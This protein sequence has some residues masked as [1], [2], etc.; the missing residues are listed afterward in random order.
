MT[1][2]PQARC[3]MSSL[4]CAVVQ[5][6]VRCPPV[7]LHQQITWATCVNVLEVIQASFVT[8]VSTS[9]VEL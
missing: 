1:C 2:K 9:K 4:T 3:V 8:M 5:T 7:S 6:A